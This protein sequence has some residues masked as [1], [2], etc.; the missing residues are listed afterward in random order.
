M[1]LVTILPLLV[2]V[3]L[4]STIGYI[5]CSTFHYSIDHVANMTCPWNI[6]MSLKLCSYDL[7]IY[8]GSSYMQN[9]INYS[10]TLFWR[11]SA[12]SSAN[13]YLHVLD[14][15]NADLERFFGDTDYIRRFYHLAAAYRVCVQQF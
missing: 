9:H 15:T 11:Y 5:V 4:T 8:D 3:W 13:A 10:G 1:I 7:G 2:M 14:G 6:P 12:R